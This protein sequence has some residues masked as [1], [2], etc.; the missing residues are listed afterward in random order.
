MGLTEI[1]QL[2]INGIDI[3]RVYEMLDNMNKEGL[4]RITDLL[5]KMMVVNLTEKIVSTALLLPSSPYPV[6]E[7]RSHSN[8]ADI[9]ENPQKTGNNVQSNEKFSD[10]RSYQDDTKHVQAAQTTK[11]H[12]ARHCICSCSGGWA[13]KET[14]CKEKLETVFLPGDF[15]S[16]KAEG[17]S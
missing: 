8:L 11:T 13:A 9:F 3:P 16:S 1:S 14:E 6:R 12:S 5:G 7:R 4:T 10:G 2:P 17:T 15:G